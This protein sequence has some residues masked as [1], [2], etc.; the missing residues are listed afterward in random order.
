MFGG[1]FRRGK[2]GQ[3]ADAAHLRALFDAL[4]ALAPAPR[5]WQ[6]EAVR[7]DDGVFCVRFDGEDE[8][9]DPETCAVLSRHLTEIREAQRSPSGQ[10]FS[11]VVMRSKGRDLSFERHDWT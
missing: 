5:K 8:P 6:A 3:L 7:G 10:A 9:L 1:L 2:A 4:A 11:R